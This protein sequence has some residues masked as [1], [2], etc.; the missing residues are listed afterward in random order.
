MDIREHDELAAAA[1]LEKAHGIVGEHGD[2]MFSG[3]G[4]GTRCPHAADVS[5]ISQTDAV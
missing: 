2:F 5:R 1:P 4:S 3:R